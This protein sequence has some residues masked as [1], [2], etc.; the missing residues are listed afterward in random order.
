M[1]NMDDN[2]RNHIQ[3][4]DCYVEQNTLGLRWKRWLTVFELFAVGKRLILN[5]EDGNNPQRRC[6]LLLLLA[7]TD[8]QDIFS[9]LPNTGDAKDYKKAVDSLNAYILCSTGR[10]NVR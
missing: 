8:V 7:G 2:E 5:E 6:T 10:H 1:K 3:T 9:T 4:F